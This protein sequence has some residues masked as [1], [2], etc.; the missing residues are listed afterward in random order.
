[1]NDN[2]EVVIPNWEAPPNIGVA[3]TTRI[4]GTSVGKFASLN[5]GQGPDHDG[6]VDG[7][8]AA[9]AHDLGLTAKPRWLKQIHGTTCVD[10]LRAEDG[11]PADASFTTSRGI[12]CVVM[13]ADCLP[14]VFASSSGDRVA[15]AH[16][17]WRG[18]CAGVLERTIEALDV[19]AQQLIAWL[20]PAISGAVYE[21]GPQVRDAFLTHDERDTAAFVANRPGHWLADLNTL[22]CARLKR[23]GVTRITASAMCTYSDAQ[24]FY[25]YRRDGSTGRMAT[26]AWLRS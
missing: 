3:T 11:T 24:R 6:Q 2:V 12:A 5:M 21:V 15:V 1:M 22:A 19:P 16:A 8:R 20:G 18:L 23:A 17:G 10:A 13:T 14:V 9:V 4:G 7:N 26:Y 25:S